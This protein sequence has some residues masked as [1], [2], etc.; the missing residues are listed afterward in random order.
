MHN[1]DDIIDLLSVSKY[2]GKIDSDLEG[3][4]IE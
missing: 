4:T 1:P 3:D 2:P